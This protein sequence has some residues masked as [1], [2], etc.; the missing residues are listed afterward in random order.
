LDALASAGVDRSLHVWKA[1]TPDETGKDPQQLLN[2]AWKTIQWRDP[3]ANYEQARSAAELA[4]RNSE[5]PSIAAE[6]LLLRAAAEYRLGNYDAA[7]RLLTQA[8][9][10]GNRREPVL[11]CFQALTEY[12]TGKTDAAFAAFGRLVIEPRSSAFQ[13][14]DASV[15]EVAA[16]LLRDHSQRNP[17]AVAR[18]LAAKVRLW[19]YDLV[20][21]ERVRDA[22]DRNEDLSE[23]EKSLAVHMLNAFSYNPHVLRE[24]ALSGHTRAAAEMVDRLIEKSKTRFTSSDYYNWACV[25]AV[26]SRPAQSPASPADKKASTA[27]HE[28]N[29]AKT[30]N[31][32]SA[33]AQ[34]GTSQE[35]AALREQW[36]ASA[37]KYL[38]KAR[39]MGYFKDA[40]NVDWLQHDV[41]F[42]S[43]HELPEF[44][45]FVAAVSAGRNAPAT[46][47]PAAKR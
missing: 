11:L 33:T 2:R 45:A 41:D 31:A 13:L 43:F 19:I 27:R 30:D 26:C 18:E 42:S 34:A 47:T 22:I 6:S 23:V 1:M 37:F 25:F 17:G 40:S 15:D 12:A 44:R 32:V 21:P 9:E 16:V 36:G 28:G 35:M 5:S 38:G 4:A 14:S 8:E 20:F 39:E 7:T 46:S 24:M 3:N 10:K 29:A